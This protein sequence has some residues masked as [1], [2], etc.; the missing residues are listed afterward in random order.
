MKLLNSKEAAATLGVSRATILNYARSEKLPVQQK[1]GKGFLF[2]EKDVLG[3]RQVLQKH[4][5]RIH[6]PSRQNDH[7]SLVEP[8]RQAG[9]PRDLLLFIYA[10]Q[11]I[12]GG[13]SPSRR[14]M[15]EALGISAPTAGKWL[16]LLQ[17]QMLVYVQARTMSGGTAP[18]TVEITPDGEQIIQNVRRRY[19]NSPP[20]AEQTSVAS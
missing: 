11:T 1:K 19:W 20:D 5:R 6:N 4:G 10:Y 16:G 9:S 13:K 7:L 2:D 17:D 14:T 15:A 3:L 12:T 18:D 8:P